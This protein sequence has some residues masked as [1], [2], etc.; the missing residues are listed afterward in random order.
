MVLW[1]LELIRKD[2]TQ[3]RVMIEMEQS[4]WRAACN[5]MISISRMLETEI[6]DGRER[7]MRELL[8]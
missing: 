5:D 7:R 8:R 6:T 2:T 1:E 3:M 4:T